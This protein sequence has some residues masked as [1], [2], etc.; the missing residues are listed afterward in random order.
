[1]FGSLSKFRSQETYDSNPYFWIFTP[2]L[3]YQY[4]IFSC[5]EVP[6]EGKPYV[7]R[8]TLADFQSF[9]DEMAAQSLVKTDVTVTTD[10]RIVTLSTCTGNSATRFIVQG[11]LEQMY[12]AK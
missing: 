10:D 9:L 11:V 2:T 4:R 8:F 5:H 7:T 3:I 1:M 12:I 6:S